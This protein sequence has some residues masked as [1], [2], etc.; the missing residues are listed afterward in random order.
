[1]SRLSLLWLVPLVLN[2]ALMPGLC[3]GDDRPSDERQKQDLSSLIDDAVSPVESKRGIAV[4]RLV[5]Q[6]R[7]AVRKLIKVVD[8]PF[9]KGELF[10][11]SSSRR[12]V[13]MRLLGEYRA[14]EAIPSLMR[15]I[16][17]REGHN[18]TISGFTYRG[19]AV[20]A[21]ERIGRAAVPALVQRIRVIGLRPNKKY[22]RKQNEAISAYRRDVCLQMLF[23]ILRNVEETNSTTPSHSLGQWH[24]MVWL[25]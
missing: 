5:N 8:E 12:N 17:L 2:I 15:W 13:A 4:R 20:H 3:L 25:R 22:T 1:M 11:A 7:A 24:W 23:N 18:P 16:F 10:Y 21:L 9:V 14:L 19:G 6:H